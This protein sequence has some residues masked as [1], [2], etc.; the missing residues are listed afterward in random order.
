[1]I[2]ISIPIPL[3]TIGWIA[4]CVMIGLVAMAQGRS[5]VSWSLAAALAS[6][7]NQR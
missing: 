6:T 1:V 2:A 3:I 7:R 5:F 4:A